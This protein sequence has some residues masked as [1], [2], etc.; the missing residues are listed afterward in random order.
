MSRSLRADLALLLMCFFWGSTF[1]LV[2]QALGDISTLLYLTLRF[3]A[4]TL[5]LLALGGRPSRP[6]AVV[7]VFLFLG[8]VL[9]THGLRFTTPSRSAFITSL[10]VVLVPLGHG[11]VK[12]VWPDRGVGIGVVL[13]LI[14]L[15]LLTNPLQST[16]ISQGDLWTLGCAIAFTIHILLVGHFSPRV[17]PLDLVTGQTL[18]ATALGAV[19]FPWGESWYLH[20]SPKVWAAVAI[21]GLVCTALAFFV[22]AWAQQATTSSHVA[23][24]FSTEP[25]F[26]WI[27]SAI[28]LGERLGLTATIGALLILA[29]IV[30]AEMLVY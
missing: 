1:V 6:G 2:K 4:A 12:R 28:L 15:M 3:G 22:Q 17:R 8:Y 5:A 21:T 26:A 13:A 24:I 29:G 14:G 19:T 18:T 30:C 11:I 23:L 9:Q 10:A 7:G 20:P 25:V 27:T 16:S